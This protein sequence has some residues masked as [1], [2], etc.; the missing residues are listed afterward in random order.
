MPNPHHFILQHTRLRPVAGLP[1]LSLYQADGVMQIWEALRDETGNPEIA[2]PFWAYVWPGGGALARY[3]AEHPE[4]VRGA[5]VVDVASGSGIGAIAALRAGAR[6][7]LAVDTDPWCVAAIAL[8]ARANEIRV[9]IELRDPTGDAPPET[10]VI[11]A[12][13]VFYEQP[14]ASR[15]AEWLRG[16]AE[17]GIR[18]L[19][20]DPGR[21]Y[22]PPGLL[23]L[24]DYD[25]PTVHG[26]EQQDVIRTGVYTFPAS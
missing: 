15:M 20:A 22:R 9:P 25:I 4:A 7:V 24:A 17:R 18:V 11:L 6:E 5:A 10:D 3:L 23:H 16:A 1:A 14:M 13:D 21:A 12:G 26:L 19:M 8:N 2:P